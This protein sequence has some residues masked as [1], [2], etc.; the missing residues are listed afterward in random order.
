MNII[1]TYYI[2]T[3]NTSMPR[4]SYDLPADGFV[5]SVLASSSEHVGWDYTVINE[6]NNSM[7]FPKALSN[8]EA[9]KKWLDWACGMVAVWEEI[10][11]EEVEVEDSYWSSE[12]VSIEQIED[13]WEVVEENQRAATPLTQL[14]CSTSKRK[15]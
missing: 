10:D 7:Y 14:R 1:N 13:R 6:L 12:L 9:V 15:Y 8:E 5:V 4:I 2:N 3:R 11:G